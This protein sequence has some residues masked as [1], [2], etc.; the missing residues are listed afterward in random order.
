MSG[1]RVVPVA[2]QRTQRPPLDRRGSGGRSPLPFPRDCLGACSWTQYSRR[3][4][5]RTVDIVP[6]RAGG[7]SR[8]D[9]GRGVVLFK[10]GRISG[11]SSCFL[12]CINEQVFN[13]QNKSLTFFPPT[14]TP[15]IK[16]KGDCGCSG[17]SSCNCGSSLTLTI[18]QHTTGVALDP[19]PTMT[20][21]ADPT[22]SPNA[23]TPERN[24]MRKIN[25]IAMDIR[26]RDKKSI[27]REYSNHHQLP[28]HSTALRPL[29]RATLP[30]SAHHTI[31]STQIQANST[32]CHQRPA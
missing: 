24:N 19:A 27:L 11:L 8:W 18:H 29:P 9:M 25:K 10:G 3:D 26:E 6:Y 16:M 15:T 23:H 4:G 31:M 12:F 1:R 22:T 20:I 2:A 21:S 5:T 17:A 28:N 14:T 13:Q 30:L 7:L 32:T